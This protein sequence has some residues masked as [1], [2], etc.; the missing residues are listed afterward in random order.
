MAA[1][2]FSRQISSKARPFITI[3]PRKLLKVMLESIFLYR[4]MALSLVFCEIFMVKVA[5]LPSLRVFIHPY[6]RVNPPPL[7][8][9]LY[10]PC[11]N[12]CKILTRIAKICYNELKI[13]IMKKT[14]ADLVLPSC[15]LKRIQTLARDKNRP[16]EEE[17]A[18]LLEMGICIC[19]KKQEL[20]K[21]RE[22]RVKK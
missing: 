1:F 16:V 15:D 2:S 6:Y 22:E 11:K 12:Y 13:A 4:A 14:E 7:P 21:P 17:A 3:S 9:P 10:I 8:Y 20:E 5:V 18:S 19:E